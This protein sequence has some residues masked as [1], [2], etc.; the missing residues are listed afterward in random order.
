MS[1]YILNNLCLLNLK[2]INSMLIG[3]QFL[4]YVRL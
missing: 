1:K 4:L 3:I 2:F